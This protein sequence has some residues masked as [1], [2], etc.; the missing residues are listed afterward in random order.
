MSDGK[1]AGMH[2]LIA[3]LAVIVSAV[4]GYYFTVIVLRLAQRRSTREHPET[5]SIDKTSVVD[6]AS[7]SLEISH[8]E[9]GNVD[10]MASYDSEREARDSMTNG[11][12]GATPDPS[13][14]VQGGTG[15]DGERAKDALR[16][17]LWIG[18]LE[19]SLITAFLLLDM[20]AGIAVVVAVKGLGRY[21]ELN[22]DT[23]ERFIIGT[24]ASLSWACSCAVIATYLI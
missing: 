18:L 14:A 11:R 10:A 5:K 4:G 22:A 3:L 7:S 20:Q 19:R 9:A 1:I 24:L 15:P 8:S 17:G 6:P 2:E 21:P 13:P 23:S 12:V 16:G